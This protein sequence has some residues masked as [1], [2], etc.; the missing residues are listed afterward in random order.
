MEDK[1]IFDKQVTFLTQEEQEELRR[2]AEKCDAL[3][4]ILEFMDIPYKF[5]QNLQR[6]V[7]LADLPI[8]KNSTWS[9]LANSVVD[10]KNKHK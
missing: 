7:V 4:Y 8:P 10:Y 5:K 6:S 9:T 1:E 2:K 3:L